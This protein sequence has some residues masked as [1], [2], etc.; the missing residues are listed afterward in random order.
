MENVHILPPSTPVPAST[1][2][3]SVCYRI[4]KEVYS[5]WVESKSRPRGNEVTET[6]P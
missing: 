4:Y 1:P 5:G 2:Q 3:A 6:V